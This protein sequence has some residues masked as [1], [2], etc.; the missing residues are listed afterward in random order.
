MLDGGQGWPVPAQLQSG[1]KHIDLPRHHPGPPRL[2]HATAGLHPHE[3]VHGVDTIVPFLTEPV[4]HVRQRPL[5][6]VAYGLGRGR[7]LRR[8]HPHVERFV[9]AEA[10]A[11]S[12]R[13]ELHR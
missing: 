12:R 4:D 8:V 5:V 7:S 13:I 11:S 2:V 3:A 9:A 10:E 1:G 6:R